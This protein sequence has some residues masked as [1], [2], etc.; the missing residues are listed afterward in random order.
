[1]R[2]LLLQTCCFSFDNFGC[3]GLRR[4]DLARLPSQ[5]GTDPDIEQFPPTQG[6]VHRFVAFPTS[7]YPGLHVYVM[8]ELNET[9]SGLNAPFTG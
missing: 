3:I 5:S 4:S 7:L 1:M 6:V 8:L 2:S 9:D